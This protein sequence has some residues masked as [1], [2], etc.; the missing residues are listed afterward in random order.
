MSRRY[1]GGSRFRSGQR[2]IVDLLGHFP[3]RGEHPVAVEIVLR[4]HIVGLGVF[5]LGVG[6]GQLPLSSYDTAL[7]FS[8]SEAVNFSWLEVL[9]EIIG[10]VIFSD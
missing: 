7:V 10:T 2:L 1:S 4:L 6:C 5:Q 9:T 8:I 3:L